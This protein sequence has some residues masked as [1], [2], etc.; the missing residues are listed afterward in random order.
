[1]SY[2]LE[3]PYTDKQRAD[4][5][6]EH[7]GFNYYKDDNCIIMYLDSESVADGVV[8]DISETPEYIAKI[9]QQEAEIQNMKCITKR[10]LLIWLYS[11]KQKTEDDIFTAIDT[12]TDVSKKYLA[13][14]SY[15][16]TNNFYY[17]NEFTQTIGL[18]LGL[19][20]DELKQCFDEASKLQKVGTNNECNIYPKT[21]WELNEKV[22]D[23]DMNKWENG[24]NDCV[25]EINRHESSNDHDRL[26]ING[27]IYY[28]NIFIYNV[29]N[30][31]T[32]FKFYSHNF[33]NIYYK[34]HIE[35]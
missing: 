12:L 5:I 19:S 9:A 2:K 27:Y 8:T 16:G 35:I 28:S 3:K 11:N 23:T 4:F 26:K 14:V 18:A 30:Y 25:N 1:M 15:S 20:V 7:Q 10:Q 17:G 29:Y 21:N 33:S 6:C 34:R 22:I 31:I 24:I 13:K 32:D